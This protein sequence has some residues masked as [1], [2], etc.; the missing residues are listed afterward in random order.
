MLIL[1]LLIAS[2]ICLA[3]AAFGVGAGRVHL[4]WLGLA[5]FVLTFLEMLAGV[6]V[7]GP[8]GPFTNFAA[9][10]PTNPDSERRSPVRPRCTAPC[11]TYSARLSTSRISLIGRP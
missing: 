5:L 4:G 3:L 8:G 2:V 7:S 1:I 11:M 6:P 9:S 10:P